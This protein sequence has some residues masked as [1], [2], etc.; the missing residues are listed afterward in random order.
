LEVDRWSRDEPLLDAG[1]QLVVAQIAGQDLDV[2]A[3]VSATL[4]RELLETEVLHDVLGR[5]F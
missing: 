2:D 3:V 5:R 4:R 1:D